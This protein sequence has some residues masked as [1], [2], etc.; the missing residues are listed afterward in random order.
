MQSQDLFRQLSRQGL[1]KQLLDQRAQNGIYTAKV[2][3]DMLAFQQR[4]T[5]MKVVEVVTPG[6]NASAVDGNL[7]CRAV[8]QDV[9]IRHWLE[10]RMLGQPDV[11]SQ[12]INL[13]VPAQVWEVPAS[14]GRPD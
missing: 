2:D 6:W 4:R 8:H 10:V 13:P 9:Q 12:E 1:R 11:L 7:A 3:C 5:G 14:A